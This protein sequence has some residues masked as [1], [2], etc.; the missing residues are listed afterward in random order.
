LDCVARR[1]A[2]DRRDG[3]APVEA[4]QVPGSCV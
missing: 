1:L 4:A 2:E 3:R